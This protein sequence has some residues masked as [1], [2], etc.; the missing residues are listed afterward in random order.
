VAQPCSA[1]FYGNR[2]EATAPSD[3]YPCPQNT[4]TNLI[5][6]TACVPCG[7]SAFAEEGQSLCTCRGKNRYFQV[8][9]GSCDCRAGYVFYGTADKKLVDGNSDLD[10]QPEVWKH[11][12]NSSCFITVLSLPSDCAASLSQRIFQSMKTHCNVNTL[13]EKRSIS[14]NHNRLRNTNWQEAGYLQA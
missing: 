8:T 6:Q 13:T 5:N 2:S 12:F 7:S 1:G 3:C 4:F 14:N 9:D 11:F 10:C